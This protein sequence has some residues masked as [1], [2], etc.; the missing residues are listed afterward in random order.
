MVLRPRGV[1]T[2]KRARNTI[3]LLEESENNAQQPF[4]RFTDFS[5]V[6]AIQLEFGEVFRISL[7]RRLF[8]AKF[9]PVKSAF[10][11]TSDDS[12]R[13]VKIHA[14]LTGYSPLK[15]KMFHDLQAAAK[16]LNVSLE[17]LVLD[18]WQPTPKKQLA[19]PTT[20]DVKHPAKQS[21]S[22]RTKKIKHYEYN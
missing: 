15:V 21:L 20:R 8:Y 10:Y 13:V 6:T 12:V 4:N 7:H 1:L 2:E 17:T 3:K 19:Q 18:P 9:P 16:W 5:R 11:V 22:D 14:V